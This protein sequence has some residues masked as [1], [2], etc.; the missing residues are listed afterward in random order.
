LPSPGLPIAAKNGLANRR[1][2]DE[3]FNGLLGRKASDAEIEGAR[4]EL[5]AA[6]TRLHMNGIEQARARREAADGA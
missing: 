6:E 4:R 2:P 3:N 5:E 1:Q